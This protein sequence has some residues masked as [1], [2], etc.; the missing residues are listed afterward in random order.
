MMIKVDNV[1]RKETFEKRKSG[2]GN[3]WDTNTIRK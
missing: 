1:K 2:L 3:K